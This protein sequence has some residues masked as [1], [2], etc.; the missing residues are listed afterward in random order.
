MRPWQSSQKGDENVQG[1][2]WVCNERLDF[3]FSFWSPASWTI[4]EV[5]RENFIS[6]QLSPP[7]EAGASVHGISITA[8]AYHRKV[9]NP[10]SPE[11]LKSFTRR[12]I[13]QV[14][15]SGKIIDELSTTSKLA[16]D[17]SSGE[18]KAGINRQ[19][20]EIVE[21]AGGAVCQ[22]SFSPRTA[23][24]TRTAAKGLCRAF[25]HPNRRFHYVVLAAVPENEYD[26]VTP[27]LSHAVC[28]ASELAAGSDKG[29][30][31]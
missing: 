28:S 30:R 11:L 1:V 19:L 3:Y 16:Q 10:Y 18:S 7:Q 25:Y 15:P 17:L 6:I 13:S 31:L 27:L 24:G 2:P 4:Q 5:V 9:E 29:T 26:L 21:K 12:F 14:D 8:F 20:K 23:A 22:L